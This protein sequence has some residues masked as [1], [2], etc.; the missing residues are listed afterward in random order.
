MLEKL[1]AGRDPS[2]LGLQQLSGSIIS[3][4]AQEGLTRL[5]P[6]KIR[7]FIQLSLKGLNRLSPEECVTALF[8][9]GD[10]VEKESILY[11]ELSETDLESMLSLAFEASVAS[12]KGE[13]TPYSVTSAQALTAERLWGSA[14][15]ELLSDYPDLQS[16]N[17][18]YDDSENASDK[19]TCDAS[20]MTFQSVIDVKGRPGDWVAVWLMNQ[21]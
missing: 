11:K 13:G 16:L 8:G 17:A 10:R 6:G 18:V 7:E 15:E 12:A 21:N 19:A 1:K 9:S 3:S 5:E 14:F 4:L 2:T 20:L